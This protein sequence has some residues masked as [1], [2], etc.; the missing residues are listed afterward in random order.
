[1]VWGRLLRHLVANPAL[2][3]RHFSTTVRARIESAI[4]EAESQHAGQICFAIETALPWRELLHGVTPRERAVEVFSRLRVWDTQ[5]NNGV[6]IYVMWADRAVEVIADRGISRQVA[7]AEWDEVCRGVEAQYA[8]RRFADGSVAAVE[9]VS[10]LLGR[11]FPSA[12]ADADELPNQ[13]VLL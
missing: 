3:R 4:R 10:A 7:Q 8:A 1:V 6:L 12:I 2:T 13:P 11:H 9:G 5:A